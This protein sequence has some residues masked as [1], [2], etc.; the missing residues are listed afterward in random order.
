[1]NSVSSTTSYTRYLSRKSQ[2]NAIDPTNLWLY[3]PFDI[4]TVMGNNV[5][6][7]ATGSI[8]YDAT[9]ISPSTTIENDKMKTSTMG[10]YGTV[11]NKVVPCSTSTGLSI[12]LWFNVSAIPRSAYY[13]LFTL[14]DTLGY[15]NGKRIYYMIDP[16]NKININ[17]Q[18]TVP[19]TVTINKDYHLVVTITTGNVGKIYVNNVLVASGTI[20]Y[21]SFTNVSG[22]NS[23]GRDPIGDGIN[24]TIDEFRLYNRVLTVNEVNVLSHP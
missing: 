20:S 19:F 17:G 3:Y 22:Y 8:V 11:I 12:S 23:I 18:L 6:N 9:L 5:G 24:G 21:P 7:M 10:K 4:S 15:P 16:S 14:Q 13:F 2:Y 1:M